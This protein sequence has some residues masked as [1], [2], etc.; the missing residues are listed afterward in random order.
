MAIYMMREGTPVTTLDSTGATITYSISNTTV[1]YGVKFTALKSWKIT[2]V[3]FLQESAY[4]WANSNLKIAPGTLAWD[5]W[6]TYWIAWISSWSL[7]LDTPY[8][9][10]EWQEY[11][12][13]LSIQSWYGKRYYNSTSPYPITWVAVRY[14]YWTYWTSTNANNIYNITYLKVQYYE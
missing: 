11:T 4:Q 13:S 1:Y 6:T 14:D 2:E 9:I 12:V 3:W 8:D 5:A 7:V 10:V